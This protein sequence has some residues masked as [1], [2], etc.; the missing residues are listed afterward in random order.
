VQSGTVARLVT[1]HE[2]EVVAARIPDLQ[3]LDGIADAIELHGHVINNPRVPLF[4]PAKQPQARWPGIG[5]PDDFAST[6][7]C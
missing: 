1:D 3:V 2:R 7:S 5:P 6:T 4:I